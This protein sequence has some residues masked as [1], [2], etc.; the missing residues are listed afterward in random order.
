MYN[1]V[2]ELVDE[3]DELNLRNF[4]RVYIFVN[5]LF[6]KLKKKNPQS[7]SSTIY[8]VKHPE[9]VKLMKLRCKERKGKNETE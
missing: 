8:A 9:Q 3:I 7:I 2:R 1:N 6:L 4:I 5:E